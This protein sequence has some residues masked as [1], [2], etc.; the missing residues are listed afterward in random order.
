MSS[1]PFPPPPPADENTSLPSNPPPH[2]R[3][4]RNSNRPRLPWPIPI[5]WDGNRTQ[6]RSNKRASR[7]A[8]DLIQRRGE[9]QDLKPVSGR[10]G[11]GVEEREEGQ[12]GDVQGQEGGVWEVCSQWCAEEDGGY[13]YGGGGQDCEDEGECEAL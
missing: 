9:G 5:Q 11:P 4:Y 6:P 12:E 1:V 10:Q 3:A 13:K 2:I 8:E 7:G